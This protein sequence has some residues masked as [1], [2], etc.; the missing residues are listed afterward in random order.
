MKKNKF[1]FTFFRLYL[2]IKSM[3]SDIDGM[4]VYDVYTTEI[5]AYRS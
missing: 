2:L 5:D 3:V 1:Y 4:S